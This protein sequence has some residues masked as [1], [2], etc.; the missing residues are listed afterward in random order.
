VVGPE[1]TGS[2]LALFRRRFAPWGCAVS[3]LEQG[4]ELGQELASERHDPVERDID[5][6]ISLG[7]HDRSFAGPFH[8]HIR[9][10]PRNGLTAELSGTLVSIRGRYVG[11][12]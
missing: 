2:G 4:I 3:G 12:P 9:V 8:L 6:S 7:E 10:S 5:P 1:H 11:A